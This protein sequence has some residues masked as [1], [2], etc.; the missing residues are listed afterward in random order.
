MRAT[1]LGRWLFRL[2]VTIGA[3][4]A[5]LGLSAAAAHAD[6]ATGGR[7]V[8]TDRIVSEGTYGSITPV[9][10]APVYGW[11]IGSPAVIQ[12]AKSPSATSPAG[13]YVTEDWGW[14]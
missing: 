5:A 7:V 4:S 12:P 10:G 6:V 3:G 9:P 2:V 8:T 14:A 11:V 1:T 13:V